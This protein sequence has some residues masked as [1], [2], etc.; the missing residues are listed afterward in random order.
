MNS[1]EQSGL[2]HSA[3]GYRFMYIWRA[4]HVKPHHLAAA[5]LSFHCSSMFVEICYDER[6]LP[7]PRYAPGA[8]CTMFAACV[9]IWC[10]L[11]NSAMSAR[12]LSHRSLQVS[13]SPTPCMRQSAMHLD[14]EH[15]KA[16][17]PAGART[18]IEIKSSTYQSHEAA[19]RV[20]VVSGG[21]WRCWFLVFAFEFT[22]LVAGWPG[23]GSVAYPRWRPELF[24]GAL[25][26]GRAP[27]RNPRIQGGA[28]GPAVLFAKS[29]CFWT[30]K[31][32]HIC[33]CTYI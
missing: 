19:S 11:Y 12:V 21:G 9:A 4:A 5:V 22:I 32:F 7:S 29:V 31:S 26:A 28:G 1:L 10:C 18:H 13:H 24:W 14:Q 6:C 16:A 33:V 30:M 25:P 17:P 23:G 15:R 8:R 27:G 20:N 3:S 2:L